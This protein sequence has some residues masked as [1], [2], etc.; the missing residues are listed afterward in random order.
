MKFL[1]FCFVVN[2]VFLCSVFKRNS[3]KSFALCYLVTSLNSVLVFAD[4]KLQ[5]FN[6][7]LNELNIFLLMSVGIFIISVV[8][9]DLVI[10]PKLKSN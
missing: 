8:K 10:Q 9:L 7:S 4:Y 1:I 5:L 2:L 3:I 6:F